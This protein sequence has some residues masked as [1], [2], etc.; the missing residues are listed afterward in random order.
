MRV[1]TYPTRNFATL[2]PSELQPPLT[3]GQRECLHILFQP[4]STGQ[5]SDPLHHLTILQ[6][7]VFLLNSRSSLLFDTITIL[8]ILMVLFIPKLQ[9]QFAEFLHH[10]YLTRLCI[11]YK[12][13]CVGLST[14][15]FNCFF[16]EIFK[17]FVTIKSPIKFTFQFFFRDRFTLFKR[18]FTNR[19]LLTYG[20]NYFQIVLR[21]S[22]QH[23][24][25]CALEETSRFLFLREQN[26]SLPIYKLIY[27]LK[28][29]CIFLSLS[30]SS[31]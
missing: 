27:I 4:Y 25:F 7:P 3:G 5:V 18:F 23:F 21:Y 9:S 14:I 1:G 30:T 12:F 6:S 15:F 26:V 29:R 11:F 24:H 20:D 10:N 16:Q 31:V 28:F 19:K 2:G 17:Y 13:T 22:Y 8:K